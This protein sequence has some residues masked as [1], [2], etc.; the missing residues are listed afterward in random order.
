[1]GW[2]PLSF[3]CLDS[4]LLGWLLQS[5]PQVLNVIRQPLLGPPHSHI[6][7]HTP[8]NRSDVTLAHILPRFVRLLVSNTGSC[9]VRGTM[10]TIFAMESEESGFAGPIWDIGKF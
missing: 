2:T 5:F 10:Q 9:R 4:Y 3:T 1:M 7:Y 6:L 8:T